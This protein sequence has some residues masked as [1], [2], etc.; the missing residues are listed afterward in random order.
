[1]NYEVRLMQVSAR[2]TAVVEAT[3]TWQRLP[4]VW[5]ELLDE[6]WACVRAGGIQSG[7]R[8]VMLYLDDVPNAEVGVQLSQPSPLTGRLVASTLPAGRVATTVHRGSYAELGLAHRAV[9][10][11]CAAQGEQVSG[12][13]WEVYGPHRNDVAELW[14]EVCWLLA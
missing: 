10:D 12:T 8:N 5:K 6:V 4:S 1:M 7:C 9:L 2:P 11:W 3:T 14:T 13:R